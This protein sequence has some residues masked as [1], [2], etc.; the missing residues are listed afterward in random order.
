MLKKDSLIKQQAEA[1]LE[2]LKSQDIA[3]IHKLVLETTLTSINNE[4]KLEEFSSFVHF[5]KNY[6]Y[7]EFK[8]FSDHPKFNV[9]H[10]GHNINID[11]VDFLYKEDSKTSDKLKK[12]KS[13]IEHYLASK[14][15]TAVIHTALNTDNN[16]NSEQQITAIQ[17]LL[18]QQQEGYF[19]TTE[20]HKFGVNF[21]N[22]EKSEKYSSAIVATRKKYIEDSEELKK[23]L[24]NKIIKKTTALQKNDKN[25]SWLIIDMRKVHH[26]SEQLEDLYDFET[27]TNDYFSKIIV[28]GAYHHEA[29]PHYRYYEFPKKV[30]R[31]S[32]LLF[33][34][35][36]LPLTCFGYYTMYT[37]ISEWTFNN[38]FKGIFGLISSSIIMI[39]GTWFIGY[40]LK[41]MLKKS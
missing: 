32:C 38:V 23:Y 4:R 15:R 6:P 3:G 36:A 39:A 41:K 19:S 22:I 25:N 33:I 10:E 35:S 17:K 29:N 1:L 7:L 27:L 8:K 5:H 21:I 26:A 31:L 28:L 9:T 24:N 18:D 13:S 37:A 14:H 20:L 11:I 30:S 2:K 12:V 34:V 40:Q 16:F